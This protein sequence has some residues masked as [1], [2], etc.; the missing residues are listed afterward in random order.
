MSDEDPPV[1]ERY[2]GKC[3]V[4][5]IDDAKDAAVIRG[6]IDKSC[7]IMGETCIIRQVQNLPRGRY[8]IICERINVQAQEAQG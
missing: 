4:A 5:E 3:F 7:Q 2:K 1:P 6:S 8:R